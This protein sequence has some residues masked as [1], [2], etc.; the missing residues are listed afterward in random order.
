MP[1]DM[2][3]MNAADPKWNGEGIFKRNIEVSGI[4]VHRETGEIIWETKEKLWKENEII[5]T[6][7]YEPEEFGNLWNSKFQ[8]KIQ[9]YFVRK[10][11]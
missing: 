10:S 8:A 3:K 1:R 5:E 11:D 7:G 4:F 9:N 6:F 2:V